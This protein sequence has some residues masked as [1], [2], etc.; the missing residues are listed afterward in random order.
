MKVGVLT[1]LVRLDEKMLFEALRARGIAF[2]R[3]DDREIVFDLPHRGGKH[4]DVVLERCIQH[5]RA[6]HALRLLEDAGVP[7]V[8]TAAVVELC[9][10]KLATSSALAAHGV[11][12]PR[13]LAAFTPESALRAIEQ[14]GYPVVL[15]PVVGSWGR[16]LARVN[17]RDAAEALL[18]HKDVL[19]GY[20]HGVFYV[21][22]YV[23]K[24]ARDI[25]AFV[26]CD[27]TI[28]AIHRASEHWITNTARGAE[29]SRRQRA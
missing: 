10:D 8:N 22:E 17:D 29:A 6:T 19:G 5:S 21:Q 25:R 16:L 13:T 14:L 2:E 12:T 23:A 20:Q 24:P 15:K 9:G 26:V 27:R 28:A 7:T 3:L 18:E 1:S 4:L 11:A